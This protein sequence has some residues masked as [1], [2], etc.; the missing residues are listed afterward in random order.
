MPESEKSR[1]D[2]ILGEAASIIRD[3]ADSQMLHLLGDGFLDRFVRAIA[4]PRA[5]REGTIYQYLLENKNRLT[6]IALLR[7]ALHVNYSIRGI[8]DGTEVFVSPHYL[9]WFAD[10]VLFLQGQERF[11]GLIGRYDG[12]QV[13]FAI[14]ARDRREGDTVGPED[15]L[16]V[17]V[18]EAQSRAAFVTTSFES[19]DLQRAV[20]EL[21]TLLVTRETM[22][23]PYQEFLMKNPWVFGAQYTAIQSH[24]ALDDTNVPDFSAVRLRD[25]ARDILEIKPPFI[26]LFKADGSFRSEFLQAW[27]QAE[28]YLDLARTQRQ[29][30]ADQK[31]LRFENPHCL[32]LLGHDLSEEHRLVILRKQR[33]NP[34]ITI[35]TY[36]DLLSLAAGTAAFV[37]GLRKK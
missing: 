15:F 21:R 37:L 17:P 25:G 8:V 12:R 19:A 3:A 30:L 5:A 18:E 14:A 31:G 34:A 10:S 6:L 13:A 28:R 2:E 32:L 4:E 23:G 27:D 26:Q 16:F 29:Y 11:A 9:Q 1:L 35:L 7:H 33:M 24:R 20:D 36:N 22:E